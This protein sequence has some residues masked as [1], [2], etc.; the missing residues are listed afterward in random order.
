MH[1]FVAVAGRGLARTC[2]SPCAVCEAATKPFSTSTRSQFQFFGVLS[3]RGCARRKDSSPRRTR[4]SV[5]AMRES[6]STSQSERSPEIDIPHHA[7][8]SFSS[9][10]SHDRAELIYTRRTANAILSRPKSD[11]VARVF[12]GTSPVRSLHFLVA[13]NAEKKAKSF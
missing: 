9:D 13:I 2:E 7:L 6:Q 4:I 5:T 12:I 3:Y 11:V 1:K 10:F 8:L